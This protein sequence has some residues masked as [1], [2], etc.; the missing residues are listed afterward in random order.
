MVNELRPLPFYKEAL[1]YTGFFSL[2]FLILGFVFV[3]NQTFPEFQVTLI[4]FGAV[5]GIVTYIMWDTRCPRCKR[6]FV[7][8]EDESKEKDLG[9]RNIKRIFVSEIYKT[10][11]GDIIGQKEDYKM[12]PAHFVQRFFYCKKCG[13]GKNHEWHDS[14]KGVFKNWVN[15]EKWNPPE[16]K[17]IYVKENE[18]GN[19]VRVSKGG[20]TYGSEIVKPLNHRESQRIVIDRGNKC[21]NCGEK[22]GLEVHH[23][24]QRSNGGTNKLSNL[25]VLC[26]KCHTKADRGYLP[27]TRL[28]LIVSDSL[29]KNKKHF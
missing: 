10:K 19:Y 25:I 12:W 29:K 26:E 16:P 27:A 2:L 28:K 5:L 15:N 7:K 20:K 17:V 22:D 24:I 6:A 8:K 21:Q 14:E 18:E 4:V 1:Y 3:F 9:E 13:H 11:E 23:I